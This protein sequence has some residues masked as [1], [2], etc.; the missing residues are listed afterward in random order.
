MI[1]KILGWFRNKKVETQEEKMLPDVLWLI[2]KQ[3]GLRLEAYKCPAGVWTIGWGT[4]FYPDGSRVKQGDKIT[5]EQADN[6]FNW[7]CV[8]NIKMP[9][10]QYTFNQKA[11]LY[12]L[13]Y[14]TGQ[15]A[16]DRSKCKKHLEA[17]NWEK[18]FQEWNWTKANGKEMNG[19]ISRRK[20][21]RFYFFNELL[22]VDA[23]EKKYYFNEG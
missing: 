15:D 16:F 22:D 23:L 9:K 5:K 11:A 1:G 17:E 7:Y 19:L 2:K 14:N 8:Q 4:T 13:I 10:G 3:E 18:A 20:E 6:I 12:S 21:E